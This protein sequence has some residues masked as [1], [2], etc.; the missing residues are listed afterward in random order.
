MSLSQRL[1]R[2]ADVA[3]GPLTLSNRNLFIDGALDHWSTPSAALPATTPGYIAPLMWQARAGLGGAGT[4][5]AQSIRTD[6]QRAL[7]DNPNAVNVA[8]FTLTTA[9]TG[10]FAGGNAPAFLQPVERADTGAGQTLTVSAKLRTVS[11]AKKVTGLVLTQAFGGSAGIVSFAKAIDWTLTDTFKRFSVRIDPPA[12]AAGVTFT[13]DFLQCGL[14]FDGAV[15]A[16]DIAELQLEKSSS[17]CSDDLTGQG[18]APTTFE[19]RGIGPELDR[20]K[21]HYEVM[22]PFNVYLYGLTTGVP[23]NTVPYSEKRAAPAISAAANLTNATGFV[24]ANNYR[25]GLMY[26]LSVTASGWYSV[27]NN[28]N[29]IIDARL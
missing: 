19:Y 5:A 29:W 2:L 18:G 21:R 28:G 16:L 24:V 23:A 27:S 3:R 20:V 7:L 26:T 22:T 11:G 17:Y 8:R 14:V 25:G 9:S 10:T 4:L 1:A 6:P 12:I 13:N 15:G